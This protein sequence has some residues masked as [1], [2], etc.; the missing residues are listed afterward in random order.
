MR[1]NRTAVVC[2]IALAVMCQ[3]GVWSATKPSAPGTASK[4]MNPQD[5]WPKW[6]EKERIRGAYDYD[7]SVTRDFLAKL[8]A[9]GINTMLL[10]WDGDVDRP[11]AIRLLKQQADWCKEVGLHVF[12]VIKLCGAKDQSRYLKPGGRCYVGANG[13]ALTKTPCPADPVFWGNVITRRAKMLAT[14]ST[15]RSAIGGVVIDDEMYAADTSNFPS[16]CYCEWC[17]KEFFAYCNRSAPIIPPGILPGGMPAS[18][19]YAWLEKEGLLE[20]FQK[21]QENTIE[22]NCKLTERTAH[23]VSPSFVLGCFHLDQLSFPRPSWVRGLGTKAMPVLAL[24]EST[25][26]SGATPYLVKI[27]GMLAAV[28]AHAKFAPGIWPRQFAVENLAG[29][30]FYSAQGPAAKYGPQESVG[31]W[32]FT[33]YGLAHPE[34]PP[35]SDYALP[36][37]HEPWWEAIRTAN[38]ELDRQAREGESFVPRLELRHKQDPPQVALEKIKLWGPAK[39]ELKPLSE[40]G[41][42]RAES[43]GETE[44]ARLRYQSVYYILAKAGE[45]IRATLTSKRAGD[46]QQKPVYALTAPSGKVVAQGNVEPD[47]SSSIDAAAPEDGLYKLALSIEQHATSVA[48]ENQY[49]VISLAEEVC[50]IRSSPRLYFYVP[51]DV[52]QFTVQAVSPDALQI[53]LV[54]FAPDGSEAVTAESLDL[55]PAKAVVEVKPEQ[56]GKVWSFQ[57]VPASRGQYYSANVTL[58]ANLP[59]YLAQ[60][61][62]ALLVPVDVK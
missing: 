33:T 37:P 9:H 56:R 23:K 43:R 42:Q 58:S 15:Q 48:I 17:L 51:S 22:A 19:S 59:Q 31:Y 1:I 11:E 39:V 29:Q 21:W 44:H 30:L 18:E 46:G 2:W 20:R 14:F 57:P 16:Y 12:V 25:Y 60:S 24:P 3:S 52:E 26:P 45:P 10:S 34:F 35:E 7:H 5:L 53:K 49:A 55:A 32:M 41:G 36:L 47:G 40:S 4:K 8:K 13:V 27:P 6:I 62:E 50:M 54:I 28:G 61:P 38:E